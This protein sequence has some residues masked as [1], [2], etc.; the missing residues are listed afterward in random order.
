MAKKTQP[1][2][3]IYGERGGAQFSGRVFLL[4][5]GVARASDPPVRFASGLKK[6]SCF[7]FFLRYESA[8]ERLYSYVRRAR[9]NRL[10]CFRHSEVRGHP[11]EWLEWSSGKKGVPSPR[12]VGLVSVD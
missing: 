7:F 2:D 1:L 4:C 9:Q 10:R 11:C 8:M 3:E 5:L 6:R 12:T